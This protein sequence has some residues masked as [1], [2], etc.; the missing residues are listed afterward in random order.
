MFCLSVCKI[1]GLDG[2]KIPIQV[3]NGWV[4]RQAGLQFFRNFPQFFGATANFKPWEYLKPQFSEGAQNHIMWFKV[5]NLC[6]EHPFF[7]QNL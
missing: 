3:M 5:H 1:L 6:F 2:V 7:N 4:G